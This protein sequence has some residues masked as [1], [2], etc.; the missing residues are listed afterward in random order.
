[1]VVNDERDP[2]RSAWSSGVW[3]ALAILLLFAF[4][5]EPVLHAGWIWDDDSYVT[6]DPAVLKPSGVLDA[7]TLTYDVH[8]DAWVSNTPQY[9]PL[10][11]TTFWVEH[12]LWGLRPLG[13]HLV[14]VLLQL[15]NAWLVIAILRRLAVPGAWLVAA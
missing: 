15:G 11:F 7:W 14:N 2:A 10:V 12:A 3:I 5:Y 4:A 1:M 13:F 8:K 6:Q 9:Y